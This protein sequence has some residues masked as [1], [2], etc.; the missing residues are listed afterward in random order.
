MLRLLR[1][2]FLITVCVA[3]FAYCAFPQSNLTQ[4]Q[5]TVTN[6]DGSPFNGTVVITFNG[7]T[8][9]GNTAPQSTSAQIYNGALSVL[10]V[11][12]TTAS[13]GSYYQAVYNSSNGLVTWTETWSVPPST[14]PVTLSQIRTSSS[15]SG[16]NGGSGGGS[17]GITL[18]INISDVANLSSTL[19]A[20]NSSITGLTTTTNTLSSTVSGDTSSIATLNTT[21][22]SFNTT[23]SGLGN[24]VNSISNTVSGLNTTVSGLGNTVAGV[25]STVSGLSTNMTGLSNTV[26]TLGATVSSLS[27]QLNA[28]TAGTTTANFSDAEVPAGT[29]N[30]TNAVFTLAASPAPPVSL[31]I[32]R[33]GL[34]QM[35]GVDFSLS[36]NTITFLNGN[37]P[38]SSD[39]IQAF[40]RMAGTGQTATFSDDETPGG[41]IN[42]T[43]PTFTLSATPNPVLDLKL[44][45]NGLLLQQNG[46]YTLSGST[47]TFTQMAM[48]QTGDSLV[49]YYRH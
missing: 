7:F 33:N 14:T 24:N 9:P 40:Y 28:I 37:V 27:N 46:D 11:P 12:S 47:I 1:P 6:P 45:K 15:L 30:G 43:N 38:K 4:V 32:Y 49:A 44:Y 17:G 19:A 2:F 21:V 5:D 18:P 8:S 20:I 41:A 29:K 16:S 25:S 35:F 39:I 3:L 10:L 31:E 23:L 34:A 48:P 22:N 42:G 36:G 26:S 13:P